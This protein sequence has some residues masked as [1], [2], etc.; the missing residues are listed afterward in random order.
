M[1]RAIFLTLVALVALAVVGLTVYWWTTGR[2]IEST[3]NAYVEADIAVIAPRIAG[4]VRTV[5][6][7]DNQPVRAGD[8]LVTLE[9]TDYRARVAVAE[10]ELAAGRSAIGTAEATAAGRAQ[11][12]REAQAALAAANAEAARAQA[13][14]DRLARL[15]EQGFVSRQ[16]YDV[17]VAEAASRQAAVTQAR[18]SVAAARSGVT[19]AVSERT[20][21]AAGSRA[22]AAQ[23]D[24]ARYELDN[25]AIRSPID[26]VVGNRFARVGQ[27][28][29]PGQQLMAVVPVEQVYVI[30]NFKETQVARM[31]PGQRVAMEV[32]AYPG[33]EVRGRIASLS[34][35]AG[36]RFS[37][38]PPENATGNFTKIVQRV[39]V[40]IWLDRPLPETLRLVPGMSVEASLDVRSKPDGQHRR[41][42]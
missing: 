42:R 9:D 14:R 41:P 40:K 35:A 32:D 15:L 29:R 27:Y 23:A 11:A 3:D 33:R 24:A 8:I 16:R 5:H 2:H 12:I 26:G 19:G 38:L 36:S 17:G 21:A 6:V 10:A 20:T 1:R 18:A 4:Y 22:A 37:I 31:S 28:V 7:D 30:A 25:T 13:D 34:P 39:P